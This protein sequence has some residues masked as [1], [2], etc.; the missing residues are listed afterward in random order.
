MIRFASYPKPALLLGIGLLQ[1][2]HAVDTT[3]QGKDSADWATTENWTYSVPNTV[4]ERAVFNGIGTQ[5]N[6]AFSNYGGFIFNGIFVNSGQKAALTI[7]NG[8]TTL[9]NLRL[10]DGA[11]ITIK[12]GAGSFSLGT[13]GTEMKLVPHGTTSATFQNDSSNIATLGK[14]IISV[15]G[16]NGVH[17]KLRFSGNGKWLVDTVINNGGTPSVTKDG[18]GTT[19]LAGLNTYLG[20][21]VIMAGTLKAGAMTTEDGKGSFGRA[22][23]VTLA[24]VEKATLDITGFNTSIGSLAGGGEKGGNVILGAATLTTGSNNADTTYAGNITGSGSLIKIGNGTQILTGTNTYSGVTTIINGSLLINTPSGSGLISESVIVKKNAT[25]GGTGTLTGDLTIRGGGTLAP[26]SGIQSLSGGGLAFNSNSIYAVELDSLAM[27]G[28][29]ADLYIAN[30]DLRLDGPVELRLADIANAPKPFVIGKVF[31]LINY[32]GSW[33]GGANNGFFSW[34][35]RPLTNGAKFTVGPNT[36]MITYDSRTGG[37]NFPNDQV[38][39]SF[40]NITAISEA[41]GAVE[42]LFGTP[43]LIAMGVLFVALLGAL[44][45]FLKLCR[46]KPAQNEL[47]N[48]DR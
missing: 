6:I 25:L 46:R 1:L 17:Y 40:V 14:K 30:G 11:G 4:A 8:T 5:T 48:S 26:G 42:N 2:A 21:T 10:A 20:E 24:N 23:A 31:S 29:E 35:D 39:G 22:S 34:G 19:T 7:N 12:A 16:G 18:N 36:W 43:T 27:Q 28:T 33:N 38:A 15:S 13:G 47:E 45:V 9:Q 41:N 32:S 44:G 3:W 37:D